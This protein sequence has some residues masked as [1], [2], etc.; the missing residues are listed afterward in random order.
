MAKLVI[1]RF[2]ERILFPELPVKHYR[3]FCHLLT[4]DGTKHGTYCDLS[5]DDCSPEFNFGCFDNTDI[6]EFDFKNKWAMSEKVISWAKANILG[7]K[8]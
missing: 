6:D 3:I 8:T 4:S 2:E 7:G 5:K 1:E